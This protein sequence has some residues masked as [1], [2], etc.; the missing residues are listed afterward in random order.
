M[1]WWLHL[2]LTCAAIGFVLITWSCKIPADIFYGFVFSV[3]F[4]DFPGN[5]NYSKLWLRHWQLCFLI[6]WTSSQKTLLHSFLLSDILALISD[7]TGIATWVQRVIFFQRKSI[8]FDLLHSHYLAFLHI[9]F[10]CFSGPTWTKIVIDSW[11]INDST[12][13]QKSEKQT[14][15]ADF[16]YFLVYQSIASC[17]CFLL[18][19]LR[20]FKNNFI[21][22][23]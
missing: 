2:D 16:W 18:Q 4:N 17:F 6:R 13:G 19:I 15:V 7:C 12:S 23:K 22:I 8:N 3:C 10:S 1:E 5:K 21:R 14:F 11:Q 20:V 9:K